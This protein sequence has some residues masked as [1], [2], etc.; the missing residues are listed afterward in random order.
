M[1]YFSRDELGSGVV[2]CFD[3]GLAKPLRVLGVEINDTESSAAVFV[4][5]GVAVHFP[6][7]N[8]HVDELFG[9]QLLHDTPP[10]MATA[11]SAVTG[12]WIL[13]MVWIG[14]GC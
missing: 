9:R 13:C 5:N 1:D 12:A 10:L 7:V 6:E 11:G 8:Y 2:G 14:L 3:D 4:R